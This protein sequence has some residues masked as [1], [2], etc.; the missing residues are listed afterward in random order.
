MT[1]QKE[2]DPDPKTIQQ[3][4]FA[5]QLKNAA[6]TIVAGVF[7]FALT[8]LENNQRN[9]IKIFSKKHDSLIKDDKLSKS[10]SLTY[11]FTSKQI[12]ICSKK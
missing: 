12:K 4:E 10:K 1:K 6:N 11:K 5:G 3:I 8:N 7:M 2:L 9:K